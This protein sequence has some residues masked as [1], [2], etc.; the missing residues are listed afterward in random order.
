MAERFS[1]QQLLYA[2]LAGICAVVS[3]TCAATT[4]LPAAV[5]TPPNATGA[6]LGSRPAPPGSAAAPSRADAP[7][8]PVL[9][10]PRFYGALAARD[11]RV[12]VSWLGDSHT[13]ADFMPGEVQKRLAQRF[14]WGGPGFLQGTSDAYSRSGARVE[15]RGGWR[16]Q[17]KSP[18][19]STAQEDGVF[20]MTGMR[21]VAE[22]GSRLSVE[23]G[24][25]LEP[26]LHWEVVFRL[27]NARDD[28]LIEVSEKRVRA[29]ESLRTADARTKIARVALES[30]TA[31]LELKAQAGKPELFGV[32]VEHGKS[33]I[34]IDN[35]GI[36]GARVATPLAW[37]E[38][39][40]VEQIKERKPRLVILAYGT[41]DVVSE[42]ALPRMAEQYRALVARLRKA[43][44]E[45]DCLL[46]GPPDLAR[47]GVTHPRV[48]AIDD[49]EGKLSAELGCGYF[50]LF[51][52]MGGS[53]SML[54]WMQETPPLGAADGVHL[55]P[56]GYAR[57]GGALADA[58]N[59][60]FD[61][62]SDD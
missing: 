43:A 7:A 42:L 22:P 4:R 16:R 29:G 3:A 44:P 52:A 12:R 26:P 30:S 1:V 51:R 49:A 45:A 9:S 34:V 17:P 15:A 54:G 56:A 47:D 37:D 14:G 27:P 53:G 13:L 59:Q 8:M 2:A 28:F 20:G 35:L 39:A 58:L 11:S 62:T 31:R 55:T 25:K 40:F 46:L 32:V 6:P 50:S 33:G 21:F 23:L 10:L 60:G 18:A 48:A 19:R 24:G 5:A 36:N 57:L 41:N 38:R 61:A